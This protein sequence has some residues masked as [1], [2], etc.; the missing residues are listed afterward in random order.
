MNPVNAPAWP[1]MMIV[2]PFYSTPSEDEL[3]QHY[4]E[5][6]EAI[7]I[8]IMLY[9]NPATANVDMTPPLV[10]RLSEIENVAYIK[11]STLDVT[12]VR[13]IVRLCGERMG[14]FCGI[15]GYE[16]F[17]N[18]AIGWVA[19]GANLMP[20]AFAEMYRRCVEEVDLEAARALYSRILPVIELVGAH[21]YVAATKAALA[22]MGLAVGPPRP[23][24][25]PPT[26]DEQAWIERTVAALDLAI[27]SE[28]TR[29]RAGE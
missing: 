3:F 25:L 9:N 14:V 10:A 27:A 29:V 11:E 21:R 23:P 28:P 7:S 26:G 24:R 8:P 19:V 13:D 1:P 5:I 18:G 17:H 4:R 20:G 15:M 16:S 12:R 6:A 2:P 22:L